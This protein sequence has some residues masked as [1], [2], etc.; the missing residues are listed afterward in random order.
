MNE[1]AY[2]QLEARASKLE[3]GVDSLSA[4]REQWTAEREQLTT[5][6]ERLAAEREQYRKLYLQTL[7]RCA[8]LERGIVAGRQTERH[9]ADSQLALQVLGMLL[10]P[11]SQTPHARP[12]RKD[13][14]RRARAGACAAAAHGSAE[15]ARAP[16]AGRH[17][18]A[19]A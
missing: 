17:R 8:T 7:E 11:D 10:S 18:G 16:A 15:A 1:A 4:E 12:V 5:E 6:R 9:A 2:R 13:R 3:A 19:A 14:S